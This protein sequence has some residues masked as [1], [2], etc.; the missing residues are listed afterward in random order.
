MQL[1][2]QSV[3]LYSQGEYSQA[4][5][6]EKKALALAEKSSGPQSPMIADYLEGVGMAYRELGDYTNAEI[7]LK[8]ALQVDEMVRG[9]DYFETALALQELGLLYL[10][11]GRYNEAEPLLQQ[12]LGIVKNTSGPNSPAM[13]RILSTLGTYYQEIGNYP[14]AEDCDKQALEIYQTLQGA[15]GKGTATAMENLGELERNMGEYSKAEPL[16]Q[17]ALAIQEKNLGPNHPDVGQVLDKL[18][19]LYYREGD[20]AKAETYL[21]RAEKI[22]ESTYGPDNPST[23]AT[24]DNLA[25]LYMDMGDYLKAAPLIDRTLSIDVKTFGTNAPIIAGILGK[26]AGVYAQTGDFAAALKLDDRMLKIDENA[27]GPE[28]SSTATALLDLG[29]VYYLKGDYSKAQTY[30]LQAIAIQQKTLSTNH[31]SLAIGLN[32]LANVYARKGYYDKAAELEGRAATIDENVLGT[33]SPS[34]GS[35]LMSLGVDYFDLKKTNE[36]LQCAQKAEQSRLAM[37]NNI[38][39]FASEQQRLNFQSQLDPYMLFAS[40][41]D[42]PDIAQAVLRHKG[43]VLDSL[44]EDKVTARASSDPDYK[45]L[46]DQLEPAQRRLTQM[47]MLA[48]KDFSLQTLTN[49]FN[50]YE[51]LS[52]QVDDL[53]DTLARNVAGFGQVRHALGVTVPQVQQ[54]I[55]SQAVLIEYIY[56][57]QYLG[58][59]KW[60]KRYGAVVFSRNQDPKWICLGAA[61]DIEKN[62]IDYQVA[63]R[64][65]QEGKLSRALR[66]LYAQLW[67]PLEAAFPAGTK[68]AIV[69]PD[70]PLNFVSFATLVDG[71]DHFLA[72]TYSFRYVASGRDL[73]DQPVDPV[74]HDMVIFAAPDYYAGG[75]VNWE[76]SFQLDP[77]PYT[78]TDAVNL[79]NQAKQWGWHVGIFTREYATEQQ[80]RA[81]QSPWILEFSTHGTVLPAVIRAP[82]KFSAF[83]FPVD[84]EVPPRVVLYNPM[85]RSC[86]A[87]A[88][89]Q[90]T[91]DAWQR[92]LVP[93]T[94]NDGIL[95]AEEVGELNLRGTWLVVLSACDTG[96][97]Q[98]WSGEGVMGMRRGFVQAGAQHLL[99][100]LWPIYTDTT[101][102]II[103]D[104]YVKLHDDNNP[105][106]ALAEVQKDWLVKLRK[107]N[108]LL[109]AVVLA[110]AFIISSQGPVQ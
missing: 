64:V 15:T 27:F 18:G 69:S 107:K 54:A 34:T 30:D 8:K 51:K 7:S 16:L 19:S 87:L 68:M 61:T 98:L 32:D 106:E 50:E 57:N 21:K 67:K 5:D 96:V 40:L 109:S 92:G 97:G 42:G 63:V 28:A 10:Y 37:L 53:E 99:L 71:G 60:E 4:L 24:L 49:R 23:A 11:T 36:A 85:S 104:F 2:H 44:L 1:D 3:L 26:I 84:S 39:S 93:P 29:S 59:A 20:F 81:L 95:T 78:E 110:G 91:I 88:G 22:A 102:E 56:Y 100:T 47:T 70:G 103:N 80:A 41:N 79:G 66:K 25:M 75:M 46:V 74:N 55:P 35:T 45:A 94:E 31:P 65:N 38:L 58:H 77:L 17:Q 33:A 12:A 72:E 108:G 62:I 43:V 83:G 13:G 9:P 105:P 101:G 89:A 76:S 82:M 14:R 86:I 73:L 6:M 52:G 90:V 48:P